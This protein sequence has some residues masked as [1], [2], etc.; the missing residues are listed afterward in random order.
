MWLWKKN[1]KI[2]AEKSKHWGIAF[3]FKDSLELGED[4]LD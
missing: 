2:I 4:P 3:I 1:D